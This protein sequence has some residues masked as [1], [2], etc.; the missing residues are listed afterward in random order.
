MQ[1][2]W[3]RKDETLLQECHIAVLESSHY[4]K[5]M[6]TKQFLKSF[7]CSPRQNTIISL[8]LAMSN[9]EYAIWH[10]AVNGNEQCL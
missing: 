8:F 7:D 1:A 3:A 4:I 10:T 9:R 6:K 2:P 5:H